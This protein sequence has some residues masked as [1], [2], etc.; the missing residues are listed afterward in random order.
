MDVDPIGGGTVQIDKTAPSSYPAN[1]TLTNIKSIRLEAVPAPG[2][3]FSKW[4]GDLSGT[5][6]PTIMVIAC[7]KKVTAN[8][9]EVKPIWWLVGSIIAGVISIGLIIWLII[10]GRTA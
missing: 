10:R 2:Y 1:V 9:S 8:F 7:N 6:N 5:T 3:R 4:S